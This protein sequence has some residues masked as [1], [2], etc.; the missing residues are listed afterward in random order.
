MKSVAQRHAEHRRLVRV[1][2]G[3]SAV[4]HAALFAWIAVPVVPFE[5]EGDEQRERRPSDALEV[6]SIRTPSPAA[7]TVPATAGA[8][9]SETKGSTSAAGRRSTDVPARTAGAAADGAPAPPALAIATEAPAAVE[10]LDVSAALAIGE[11]IRIGELGDV[12]AVE[13]GPPAQQGAHDHDHGPGFWERI[14][15]DADITIQHGGICP[16]DGQPLWGSGGRAPEGF[17]IPSVRD[18][19]LTLPGGAKIGLPGG[20]RP[21]GIVRP[22]GMVRP[23]GIA[24]PGGIRRTGLGSGGP[25]IIRR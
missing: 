10:R 19:G 5:G 14:F 24:K 1:G 16:I 17:S 23:G 6:I 13:P 20:R 2:V 11:G 12:S 7:L 4:V 9:E 15:G 25:M 22:G 8:V 21:G 3:A 18:G